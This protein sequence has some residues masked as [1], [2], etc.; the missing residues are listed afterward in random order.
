MKIYSIYKS[1]I[2]RLFIFD[3]VRC[4]ERYKYIEIKPFKIHCIQNIYLN[5]SSHKRRTTVNTSS[6]LILL[7]GEVKI[8]QLVLKC[9]EIRKHFTPFRCTA[10]CKTLKKVVSCTTK[11]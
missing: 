6:I 11:P 3:M 9:L 2:C 5:L 7:D 4:C 1:A 10:Y 8:V